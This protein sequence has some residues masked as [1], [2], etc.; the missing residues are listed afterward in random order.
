MG[1]SLVLVPLGH[2]GIAGGRL[3]R[4]CGEF[5]G[6]EQ[7]HLAGCAVALGGG[8]GGDDLLEP[9]EHAGAG[10]TGP[11]E[12]AGFDEVFEDA[13]VDDLG[14]E[15][16]REV[17]ERGEGAVGFAFV[18]GS[19]HRTLT[20]VLDGSQSVADALHAGGRNF[21]GEAQLR[22][23]EIRRQDID[24]HAVT[25]A[26]EDAD[27]VGV[28]DF[29]RKQRGHELD[30]VVGLEIG[31]P[32]GNVAVAGGVGLVEAIAGEHLDLG[33]D[34]AG[35]RLADVVVLGRALDEL[36]ALLGH[37][38]RVFF[39][40]RA[41]QQVGTAER[42][43]GEQFGRVLHLFLIDHHAVGI[44]A[45]L[46]EQR[47]LV[48]GLLAAFFHLDHLVDELHGTRAVEREQVDD[49]IN[50]LDLVFAA[51]FHH[52]AGFELEYAHRLAA[53]EQVEGRLVVER[54]LGDVETRLV[55]ADV[56]HSLMDHGEVSQ[57]EE[58]HF[59][60]A[61]LSDG[62]HVVLRDHFA[63]VAAGE[64]HV[65]IEFAVADHDAGGVDAHVAVESFEGEGV[66][67]QFLIGAGCLDHFTQLGVLV[68]LAPQD[69]GAVF[70]L[71][72]LVHGLGV[73][74]L[75]DAVAI[76]I[77]KPH[78][79]GDVA[80][81]ALGPH[82]AVGDDVG[83]ALLAV[84]LAHVVDHLGAAG[85]A[86]VDINVRRADAFRVE[87]ALEKQT[88]LDR[89]D[90]GDPHGVGDEGAGGRAAAGAHRDIV[91]AR[92]LDEIRRD[93]EVGGEAHLV[94]GIHLVFQAFLQ[95]RV[96]GFLFAITPH[97]AFLTDTHEVFLAR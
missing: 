34:L 4:G 95:C 30:R 82:G 81:D 75:R 16:G 19:G 38:L 97:H 51:G 59:Q 76:A 70:R 11:I 6:V 48:G 83:D 73:D 90:I 15:A 52:A 60:K 89:A 65:I 39:A 85:L 24:A 58:V 69:R 71:V 32:I 57:A 80:H 5:H 37:F 42:V 33:E 17:I 3:G 21:R 88:E 79:A 78:H 25:L 49:V 1:E 55:P 64:R 20:D 84:F 43:A 28:V 96:G 29:V 67:P 40:H 91:V 50:L 61:H 45:H 68:E 41:A 13:L 12:R 92:P 54:D 2:L 93:E 27:L 66:F 8:G 63:L 46:F 86:E 72:L 94:D 22:C 47:M 35:E 26:N 10:F 87:E 9:G 23:V 44:A 53:V 56:L 77:G 74:E 18:D 62:T 31:R 7:R 36:A 14:I